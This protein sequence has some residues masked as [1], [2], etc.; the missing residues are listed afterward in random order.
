MIRGHI[1]RIGFHVN[2]LLTIILDS[3]FRGNDDQIAF[4]RVTATGYFRN[5]QKITDTT[6]LTST[7]VVIGK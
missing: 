7:I 2:Q 6:R 3:R 5:N 1:E 4:A